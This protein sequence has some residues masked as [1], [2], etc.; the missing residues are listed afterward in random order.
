M[1]KEERQEKKDKT[2]EINREERRAK[3]KRCSLEWK[4]NGALGEAVAQ[5]S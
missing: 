1:R 3:K 5:T 2:R 4:T